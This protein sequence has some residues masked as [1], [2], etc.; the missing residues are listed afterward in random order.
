L[1]LATTY[2]FLGGSITAF[3]LVASLFN[4]VFFVSLEG[5]LVSFFVSLLDLLGSF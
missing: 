3:G 1:R 2:F 5:S 4:F